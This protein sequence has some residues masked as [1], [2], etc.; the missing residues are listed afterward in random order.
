METLAAAELLY[1]QKGEVFVS[2]SHS[3]LLTNNFLAGKLLYNTS[4]T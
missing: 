3:I 2:Q 4:N 1:E